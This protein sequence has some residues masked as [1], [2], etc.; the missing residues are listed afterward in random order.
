[1]NA[2]TLEAATPCEVQAIRAAFLIHGRMAIS[3][4]R[5]AWSSG[6]YRGQ[7]LERHENIL[8]SMR[9]RPGGRKALDAIKLK[10]LS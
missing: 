3:A 1:M 8:Q 5:W 2:S 10:N 4:I 7:G 9:N 6:D